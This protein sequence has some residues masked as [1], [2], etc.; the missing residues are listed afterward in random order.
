MFEFDAKGITSK[1]EL[2]SFIFEW[3]KYRVE[4]TENLYKKHNFFNKESW[5][6][7]ARSYQQFRD[8]YYDLVQNI[9]KNVIKKFRTHLPEKCLIYQFGSFPK[10]TERILSDFDITV[11][12]D[13]PKTTK[14]EVAEQL[15]AYT[16][17]T[18]FNYSIDKYHGKF[19]HYPEMPELSQYT[20]KDNNYRLLFVDGTIDYKCGPETL[21]E[22]LMNTKNVRDYK[23]MMEGYREK[24]ELKCDIDCLYSNIIIE[25]STEHHFIDDLVRLEHSYDICDSYKFNLKHYTLPKEFTISDLKILLKKRGIVELYIFFSK[26]RKILNYNDEYNIDFKTIWKNVVLND[27]F[28][29]DY[30]SKLHESFVEFI[31]YF[32]RIE[33]TLN[34]RNI[35]LSSRCYMPFNHYSLNKLLEEDWGTSTKII[36]IINSRNKLTSLIETGLN[37]LKE[38]GK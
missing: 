24:Y 13:A 14:Y 2:K 17:I 38:N 29:K 21:H 5:D 9:I 32:N 7:D 4:Q 36:D 22:N 37:I 31:F 30:V 15:I 19:Q 6:G 35:P 18:I 10:R 27:F 25:N 33:V 26:L 20:E 12:Y 1:E 11:C 8:D 23:T 28:G 34:K 16:L 3:E